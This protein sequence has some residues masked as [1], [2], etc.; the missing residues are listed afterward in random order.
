MTAITATAI[1][2]DGTLAAADMD[3][4][5]TRAPI[6]PPRPLI[7]AVVADSTAPRIEIPV[8]NRLRTPARRFTATRLFDGA[9]RTLGADP[10]DTEPGRVVGLIESVPLLFIHGDAD[11]AVPLAD[12]R[13]LVEAA[14][15]DA[16][17][18]VVA[19]ADHSRGHA[20][21]TQDYERRVTDF[22]RVAFER[23]RDDDL[24]TEGRDL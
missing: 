15:P 14:G 5:P 9:A 7:V 4:T 13:R 17:Q 10:R 12:G 6:D 1:L 16:E 8:A 18:W 23:A 19:G 20:T 21:A 2:G 22:L 3:P 11:T 24:D